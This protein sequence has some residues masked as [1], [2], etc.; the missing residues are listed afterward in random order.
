MNVSETDYFLIS[1]NYGFRGYEHDRDERGVCELCWS[2][3]LPG[4]RPFPLIPETGA[5]SFGRIVTGPFADYASEYF[6]VVDDLASGQLVGYLTGAEGSAVNTPDGRVPWMAWRDR[7][8]ARIAENEFGE[9]SYALY[10]PWYGYMEGA[11][12]LYTLSLGPRAIQFLLH[13]KNNNDGEMPKAPACPEYHFHVAKEH[14]GKGIGSR[15]I[16]H[17]LT[18]FPGDE[19]DQACAQVTVCSGQKSLDYYERM[20]YRGEQVWQVYDKRETRMYTDAEKRQWGLG[21][22]VENVSLVA[23]RQRL[24]AFVRQEIAESSALPGHLSG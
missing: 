8:A 5:I 13:A 7:K 9:L 1:G 18:R 11:K 22:V 23:K 20:T 15:F 19:Y 21:P 16:E 4:G 24:L 14:R 3:A 10:M 2:N 6:Y 17:F 12:F